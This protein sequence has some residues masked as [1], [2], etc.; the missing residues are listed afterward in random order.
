MSEVKEYTA[1][2][3]MFDAELENYI[4]QPTRPTF[5]LTAKLARQFLK[6]RGKNPHDLLQF[7]TAVKSLEQLYNDE[8]RLTTTN[9]EE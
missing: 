1:E 2:Q 4:S 5:N 6:V 3:Y 7:V 8:H 9:K